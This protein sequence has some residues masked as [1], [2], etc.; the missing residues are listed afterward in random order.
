MLNIS[1]VVFLERL[2]S[3]SALPF[4]Q[5]THLGTLYGLST[6]SNA[7][8]RLRFYE[9]ALLDPTSEAAKYFAP[10]AAKWVVGDDGSGAVQGRMK[11]CR[12]VLRAVARADRDLAIGTFSKHKDAFHP[13][14]RKLIE[15]VRPFRMRILAIAD[16]FTG[17]RDRM[18]QVL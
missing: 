3:Y 18:N 10:S 5:I 14:A 1:A 13:I 4:A 9:A 6:T 7:E 11:F 12:P 8:L 17:S 15:K 16:N 2:H